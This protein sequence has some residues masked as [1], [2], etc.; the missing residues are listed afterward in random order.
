VKTV[1]T[2]R[3]LGSEGHEARFAT[4]LGP[5]LVVSCLESTIFRVSLRFAEGWKMPHTWTRAWDQQEVPFEG[6][7]RERVAGHALPAWKVIA[8]QD[9]VRLIQGEWEA[10][11]HL[12]S[13][14]LDWH[15]QGR[16]VLAGRPTGTFGIA[17]DGRLE[18]HQVLNDDADCW[19]LGEAA[20]PL[21]RRGRRFEMRNLDAMG[22]DAEHTDPL[23]KH[24]PFLIHRSAGV[25]LGL[26]WDNFAT[27]DINLGLERDNYHGPYFSWRARGGDFDMFL[28]AGPRV[29][30]V[31]ARFTRLTGLPMLPPAWAL[32]YSG[33][34][35]AY[36][37]APDAQ[38]QMGGFLQKL[39]ETKLPCTS[40]HLS[41]GY[42]S[43]G[44]RRYVFTWN[45]DKF[46]DPKTFVTQFRDAGV[47]LIPNVKPVLLTDHPRYAEARRLFVRQAEQDVPELSQFWDGLGSHLDF[48]NP[49]TVTWWKA[50]LKEQLLDLGVEA[51]WND[52]NEFEV[53]EEGAR[54]HGGW[55][56]GLGRPIQ[57]LLMAK[58]SRQALQEK[59][60]DQKPFVVSRSGMPGMQRY[61]Q[62]W[63]G[64]N[65]TEWKTLR[66]NL[67]MA[68]NLSL[69][70]V[71][72]TGHDL[73]GFSGPRPEPELFL[74]WIQH[75]IFYPRFVIHSWKHEGANE[76]WMY[77]ELLPQMQ[78]LFGLRETL[79]P[80]LQRLLTE[81]HITGHPILRPM[82]YDHDDDAACFA[83]S[84]DFMLGDA[85]LVANVMVP[86]AKTRAVLLPARR[87]WR[88][89]WTGEI[90]EGGQRLE[91]PVT[92]DS[93][94]MF[95]L[96]GRDVPGAAR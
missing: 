1:R 77:P 70:G 57:T 47:R 13:A 41:S 32:G 35:M 76:P 62:T 27:T 90:F 44:Q 2:L 3:F 46:P 17:A 37:D 79:S 43:I 92:R 84:D 71:G 54:T 69:S 11:L 67:A 26:F 94:P 66:F 63:S 7:P 16:V 49:A 51:V 83:P 65:R 4:D 12:S 53:W 74:R 22:Y 88:C 34:T 18:H 21:S 42:T 6:H 33:S 68:L 14:R 52:N 64:D 91:L 89:Y 85:L 38:T 10:L 96:E 19:G 31:T 60:P 95:V 48:T 82:F 9:T 80:Y 56:I 8:E 50:Q 58:A 36:T 61:V 72:N 39:K 75:G 40:F 20:G 29:R 73:G 28:V 24:F 15:Y 78:A 55:P 87:R 45:R 93:W 86:E 30:D 5:T 25:A 23:Y 59:F 81:A